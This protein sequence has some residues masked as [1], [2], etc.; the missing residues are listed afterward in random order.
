MIVNHTNFPIPYPLSIFYLLY[1][2]MMYFV[3]WVGYFSICN[4]ICW[5][6]NFSIP[7]SNMKIIASHHS[8]TLQ[9]YETKKKKFPYLS[10]WAYIILSIIHI[11]QEIL[12]YMNQRIYYIMYTPQN[13]NDV[14]DMMIKVL[15][16][17]M[18][19]KTL[20]GRGH[21]VRRMCVIWMAR[22]LLE[23]TFEL[24]WFVKDRILKTL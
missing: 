1:V 5:C 22:K 20:H 4:F 19:Y 21:I 17:E 2:C 9:G 18:N 7:N 16:A 15:L 12:V 24:K 3:C 14:D 6:S 10:S 13:Y 23:L 11:S 8:S